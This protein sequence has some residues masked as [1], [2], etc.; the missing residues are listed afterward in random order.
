[1]PYLPTPKAREARERLLS[2]TREA[3][4]EASVPHTRARRLNELNPY[5]FDADGWCEPTSSRV[6]RYDRQ[7]PPADA[8]AQALHAV[9]AGTAVSVGGGGGRSTVAAHVAALAL[10]APQPIAWDAIWAR[11]AAHPRLEL[12]SQ[13]MPLLED[14]ARREALLQEVLHV[15][16]R[17]TRDEDYRPLAEKL[18][19]AL[20]PEHAALLVALL[21]ELR[22]AWTCRSADAAD[23][24]YDDMNWRHAC[25]E[26][27]E[28]LEI[29]AEA[30]LPAPATADAVLA[31]LLSDCAKL[32]GNFLT[33]HVDGALAAFLLLPRVLATDTPRERERLVGIFQAILEHQVGPPRFMASMVGLG[34]EGRLRAAGKPASEA[35]RSSLDTLRAKIADP[36]NPAHV[37]RHA[38]GYG[39]LRLD[40][41]ERALLALIGLADWYVPHPLTPWFA[42]SSAVID[43]DSLVNYVT[44]D[45][46]GKIVAICGPGTPFQDATVFHSIFSCGASF[47]DAVSVMSDVAMGSVE[48]G[49]KRTRTLIDKVRVGVSRELSRGLLAFPADAFDRICAEE[50][51]DLGQLKVRRLHG[52]VAV[53]VKGGGDKLPYWSA[54]LDY[55]APG[56]A[57]E[58]A[59]LVRRKVADL[60]R[61][62]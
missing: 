39:V 28:V 23:A 24:N 12:V 10:G 3:L 36:L 15:P 19:E 11:F 6:E 1:L 25:G 61:A 53:E 32:R 29:G 26:V 47:V 2:R 48:Q 52:L 42:M 9:A 44:P 57:L 51:V 60:L 18:H 34:I 50:E 62:V 14:A 46:V 33:H 4:E 38:E 54:P 31:S 7:G 59:K 37:T 35:V 55:S 20:L 13:H 27:A 16:V 17:T 8:R 30:G 5:S 45:G 43:A 22:H 58:T 21:V 41:G 49:L 40:D 56:P